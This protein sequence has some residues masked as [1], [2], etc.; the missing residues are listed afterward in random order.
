MSDFNTRA[1]ILF[2]C[3]VFILPFEWQDNHVGWDVKVTA[4]QIM[5]YIV[6]LDDGVFILTF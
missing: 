3:K 5:K 2:P 1:L 4:S 6:I